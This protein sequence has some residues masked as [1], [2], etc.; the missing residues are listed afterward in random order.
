MHALRIN[1]QSQILPF[2]DATATSFVMGRSLEA[3]QTQAI[4]RAGLIPV[5]HA[6]TDQP[7]LVYSDRVWFTAAFLKKVVATAKT[8]RVCIDD[9]DY[10]RMNGP[11]Q[12]EARRPEVAICPA[13]TAPSLDLPDLPVDLELKEV[14]AMTL[15]PAMAHANQGPM[16][17]GAALVHGIEHWSH[18]LRVN[19]LALLAHGEEQKQD[20]AEAPFWK[21][22]MIGLGVLWRA[23]GFSMARLARGLCRIGK[24]CKIHPTAVLEACELGDN[25]EVGP[26]AMLR[27]CTVGEGARIEAYAHVALSVIGPRARVGDGAM[28]NLSVL[29]EEAFVSR[30][31][32][33]QMSLFGRS[34]FLAVG[35]TMLDLSFGKTIRVW[36]EGKFADSQ[37]YFLG[38]CIGHRAKLGN[39]VRL[40]YGMHVPNDCFLVAGSD[41]LLRQPPAAVIGAQRVIN[42]VA[43]EVQQKKV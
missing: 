25:V 36:Q 9:E 23:R 29:M 38:G 10:L 34:C 13:G 3:A 11:L 42:G 17:A 12:T 5:Q 26:Y 31:G 8:G 7:Y 32:G 28:V 15:H 30:G 21:K 1:T 6:P 2:G 35:V 24:G 18:L 27:A 39:G 33:F 20:F 4:L 16:K 40:S 19:L 37:S 22:M 14:P 41:D 43:V